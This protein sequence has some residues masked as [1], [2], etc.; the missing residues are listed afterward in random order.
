MENIDFDVVEAEAVLYEVSEFYKSCG[1][2]ASLYPKD[3][4]VLARMNSDIVGVVRLC[5]EEN[6]YVLRT[7]QVREDLQGKGFG[8]HPQQPTPARK[9]VGLWTGVRNKASSKLMAR[10]IERIPLLIVL[11]GVP[12]ILS[13]EKYH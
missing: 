6:A 10:L 4:L 9:P 3:I 7:M 12:R 2:S 11:E 8:R 13:Y 1:R 5:H